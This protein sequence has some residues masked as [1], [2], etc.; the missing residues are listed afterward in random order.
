MS[1]FNCRKWLAPGKKKAP[2]KFEKPPMF[3]EIEKRVIM[4]NLGARPVSTSMKVHIFN[5]KVIG[6]NRLTNDNFQV[7]L[8][9]QRG[10]W[11]KGRSLWLEMN[12]T[13]AD[14]WI[15]WL[16]YCSWFL[17][18]LQLQVALWNGFTHHWRSYGDL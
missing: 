3:D 13:E 2:G 6:C 15:A 10:M 5:K 8:I 9:S 11:K 4:G 1:I 18:W 17:G 16:C 14:C 12:F 7:L